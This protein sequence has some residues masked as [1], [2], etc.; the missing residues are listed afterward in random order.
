MSEQLNKYDDT[1]TNFADQE[2]ML[3]IAALEAHFAKLAVSGE[4]EV[5]SGE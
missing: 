5:N 3:N 4:V 1:E 2:H